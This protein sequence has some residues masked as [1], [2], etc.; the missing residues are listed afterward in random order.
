MA[1]AK[2]GMLKKL[3]KQVSILQRKERAAALKLRAALTK[4]KK[5]AMGYEKKLEKKAKEARASIAAAEAA[6]YIRLAE[7]IKKRARDAK[8]AKKAKKAVSKS[9][10]PKKKRRAKKAK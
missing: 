10:V 8:K 2:T 3:K 9:V 1:L 4:A 6:I 7:A 5:I